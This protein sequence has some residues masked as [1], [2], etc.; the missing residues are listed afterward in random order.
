MTHLAD[1]VVGGIVARRRSPGPSRAAPPQVTVR[2]RDPRWPALAA[3]LAALRETRRCSVRIVDADC[4]RGTMLLCAARHARA[5]GFGSIG[6][7]SHASFLEASPDC[8]LPVRPPPRSLRWN[9][10]RRAVRRAFDAVR[11]KGTASSDE[12]PGAISV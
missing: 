10:V 8:H 1:H 3:A 7:V 12:L 4:G 11:D 2:C 6:G 9:S 5:L